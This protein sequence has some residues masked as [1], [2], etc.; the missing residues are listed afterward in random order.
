VKQK[1]QTKQ[2][3]PNKLANVNSLSQK[4]ESAGPKQQTTAIKWVKLTVDDVLNTFPP[5]FRKA[6]EYRERALSCPDGE[7][8]KLTPEQREWREKYRAEKWRLYYAMQNKLRKAGNETLYT[9]AIKIIHDLDRQAAWF[10]Q[11]TPHPF[12][13]SYSSSLSSLADVSCRYLQSLARRGNQSA[14]ADLAKLSVEMTETLTDLLAGESAKVEANAQLMRRYAASLPYWPMLQ[15]RHAAANNHFPR[16]ADLLELGKNSLINAT[17]Q[18]NY[19]LQ[20]PINRFVWRCLKHFDEVH[21]IIRHSESSNGQNQTWEEMRAD[22]ESAERVLELVAAGKYNINPE[23]KPDDP[24]EKALEPYVFA[25]ADNH[26]FGIIHRG[27]IQIYKNS[28]K[29]DPLTKKNAQSWADIAIMPFVR[30]RF[31]DL[32]EVDELQYLKGKVGPTGKR[33][34]PVRK[35]VIQAL[36]QL[37]RNPL[38]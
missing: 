36:E 28:F 19:S 5:E 25:E 9:Q 22:S 26:R 21:W 18:A 24:V 7:M 30:C 10:A 15:F 1:C 35:A 6:I 32:R 29:L 17:E 38:G 14:I 16:V 2:L 33:Y 20:T 8:D 23:K 34:A 4:P 13:V 12:K 11:N 3:K 37:A 27:E 31:H